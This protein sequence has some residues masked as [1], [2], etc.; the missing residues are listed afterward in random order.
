M[1][2]PLDWGL[3]HATRM[4]PLIQQAIAQGHDVHLGCSGAA[5][6][7]L[8]AYFPQLPH[9]DLPSYRISYY[10]E[11]SFVWQ[12]ARQLPRIQ[13]TIQLEKNR[14]K[15][16]QQVERFD[17]IVSDNRYGLVHPKTHCTLVTHQL[18]PIA[19]APLQWAMRKAIHR[20]IDAFDAC[21]VPDFADTNS[22][23][24]GALSHGASVPKNTVYI[25]PLS[26]FHHRPSSPLHE[27]QPYDLVI[28]LSCPE[29]LRS[30]WEEACIRKY[31]DS[32]QRVALLTRSRKQSTD[33]S[34]C[35]AIGCIDLYP[36]ANDA[37][38]HSLLIHAKQVIC[39]AGYST[40]M[41]MHALGIRPHAFATPGQTEQN[42]LLRYWAE[43]NWLT[44]LS[45]I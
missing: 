36:Q 29:P 26:R 30:A 22:C 1:I 45:R 33:S 12:M 6:N 8:A 34:P 35:M 15:N 9:H 41:D 24:S 10:S 42:Y 7:W 25:G 38:M 16:L 19:P 28:L 39:N 31:Q 18:F 37:L 40:L 27:H 13:R 11:Q 21:H 5:S 23:L 44:P 20:Y 32:N 17:R 3:G 14:L 2:A 43:K 4:V